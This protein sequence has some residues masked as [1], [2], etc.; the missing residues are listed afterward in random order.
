MRLKR[1][2]ASARPAFTLVELLVVMAIILV[3]AAITLGA[4]LGLINTQQQAVTEDLFRT[5]DTKL[6][7]HW[8][9]VVA[10]AKKETPT[11]G[12]YLLAGQGTAVPM[13]EQRARV[14]HVKLRLMQAFPESFKE[15][16]YDPVK[17]T[18]FYIQY[19]IGTQNYD[20]LPDLRYTSTYKT[21][22][23]SSTA[24][25][26]PTPGPTESSACLLMILGI[27]RGNGAPAMTPDSVPNSS[28]SVQDTNNDGLKEILDSWGTPIQFKRFTNNAP[29]LVASEVDSLCP[30][31][32]SSGVYKDPNSNTQPLKLNDPLDVQGTLGEN[33]WY[34]NPSTMPM[35]IIVEKLFGQYTG[36][37]SVPY[38]QSFGPDLNPSSDDLFS[39]R[40]RGGGHGD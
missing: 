35:R 22:L 27:A 37:Y 17:K 30:S 12:V 15:I 34:T 13:I 21:A 7:Q 5:V 6:R 31:P 16:I 18:P 38:L 29:P 14:I 25:I 11:L 32:K 23:L 4:I 39:F 10:Q 40:L 2:A 3:L 1:P 24:V 9:Y 8:S 20:L 26:G 33:T 28:S 36:N 19:P